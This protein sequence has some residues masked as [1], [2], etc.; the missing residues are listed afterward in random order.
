MICLIVARVEIRGG[1]I[2]RDHLFLWKEDH[3]LTDC[4][5][6]DDLIFEFFMRKDD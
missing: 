2:V 4:S 3:V 5:P 6:S 1:P